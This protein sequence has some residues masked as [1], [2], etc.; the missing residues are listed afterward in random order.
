LV[1]AVLSAALVLGVVFRFSREELLVDDCLSAR[2][3]SFDYLAMTC[4]LENNHLYVPYQTRHPNDKR[5]ALVGLVS[6]LAFLI[7]YFNPNVSKPKI[8]N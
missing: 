6:M 7:G 2:R 5:M 3:G 4:D 8:L 1:A